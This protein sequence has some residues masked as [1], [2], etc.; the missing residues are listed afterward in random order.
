MTLQTQFNFLSWFFFPLES[1]ALCKV[2]TESIFF[3]PFLKKSLTLRF[4]C[5]SR[6]RILGYSRPPKNIPS[7]NI[8]L[9]INVPLT[10]INKIELR[11]FSS[12]FWIM[13][14]TVQPT[15]VLTKASVWYEI[16]VLWA[17]INHIKSPA[18]LWDKG[19]SYIISS[20]KFFDF[21]LSLKYQS[22]Y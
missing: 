11:K 1:F 4:L 3:F 12:T 17:S 22:Q 14:C 20:F 8:P 13:C 15:S 19:L 10:L 18:T 5:L 16:R 21:G 6:S 9:E 2:F 7:I